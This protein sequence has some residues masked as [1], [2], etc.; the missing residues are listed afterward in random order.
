MATRRL[1]AGGR[2]ASAALAALVCCV[3][4]GCR[5]TAPP[6]EEFLL[7]PLPAEQLTA[8]DAAQ[9]K[10]AALRLEPLLPRGFLDRREIG[11]REGVV[12]AGPY[13]YKRWGEPPAEAVTRQFV[14]LLRAR[15]RFEQVDASAAAAGVVHVQG[16]LLALHEES[17]ADGS[18]PCGVAAIELAVEVFGTETGRRVPRVVLHAERS[19]AAASDTMEAMVA[20]ISAALAQV[21][22]E[23]A[24]QLEVIAAQAAA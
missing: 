14:E 22:A 6:V 4:A 1:G 21:L 2:A 10:L 12:R 24:A 13:H 19:I 18:H 15:G 17:A 16:E 7:A 23:L 8:V 5:N 3:L 9:R 11:W 20:A